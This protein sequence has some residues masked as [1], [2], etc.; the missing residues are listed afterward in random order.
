VR[1]AA[2]ASVSQRRRKA[3]WGTPSL[4]HAVQPPLP[5]DALRAC[6]KGPLSP[7]PWPVDTCTQRPEPRFP[8][9]AAEKAPRTRVQTRSQGRA[10]SDERV[11]KS[12]KNTCSDKAIPKIDLQDMQRLEK[13]P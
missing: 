3:C 5:Q 1:P 2:W 8:D 13:I 11:W 10:P 6:G 7:G 9:S 4:A 12:E